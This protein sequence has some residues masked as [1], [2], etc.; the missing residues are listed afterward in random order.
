MYID[1]AP[2]QTL[3][4][5]RL[6]RHEFVQRLA[7]SISIAKNDNS[8]VIGLYGPWGSGKSSVLNLMK[9]KL[10]PRS[11]SQNDLQI[12]VLQFDPW[13]FNSANELIKSFFDLVQ[14]EIGDFVQD[15]DTKSQLN[16]LFSKYAEKLSY[17]KISFEPKISFL[18][19]LISF[20]AGIHRE[21]DSH[22]DIINLRYKIDELLKKN[23]IKVIVL[24]DNLDRLD[25]T[26]LMLML[27]LVK[28][29][30]DFPFFTYILAFDQ[31]QVLRVLDK[32]KD[33]DT[34]YLSK[35][36]QVD[37]NL[38]HIDQVSIDKYVGG[39][40]D[41]IEYSQEI[42][43]DED[44]SER[45]GHI[46]GN[47]IR[48]IL[49]KDFRTAKR[50]LN[51]VAFSMPLVK[52]EVNF[53]DF[54]A[55]E[56]IRVFFPN[57][58]QGLPNYKD[59]LTTFDTI[60]GDDWKMRKRVITFK[61]LLDWINDEIS[62]GR[63]GDLSASHIIDGI[64]NLLSQLFPNFGSFISNPNNPSHIVGLNYVN[65]NDRAQRIC[66]PSH[67][68]KYFKL[69]VQSSEIPTKLINEF[70][71]LLNSTN[72]KKF[73]EISSML[74][75]Y[76]DKS[77]YKSILQK[78]SLYSDSLTLE[79]KNIL[80][81]AILPITSILAWEEGLDWFTEARISYLLIFD[82]LLDKDD[83]NTLTDKLI[84]IVMSST[85][86][87]FAARVLSYSY[88]D[89]EYAKVPKGID[90]NVIKDVFRKRLYEEIVDQ[91]RNIF[92]LYPQSYNEILRV[93]RSTS[94]LDEE[95]NQNEYVYKT[96]DKNP[97]SIPKFLTQYVWKIAG[98]L[99]PANFEY[100][101]LVKYYQD[102]IL[103]NLLESHGINSSDGDLENFAVKEFIRIY[104]NKIS[105]IQDETDQ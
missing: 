88:P 79:G 68:D 91:D 53:A 95:Q 52:G 24:I 18:G 44:F 31:E 54:L 90:F 58:Y 83:T 89:Q 75:D 41:E 26:E 69:S 72:K 27:K 29:C 30:S 38:P 42:K 61:S 47:S 96:L 76:K 65:V 98:T 37:V 15:E 21:V 81:D 50:Y 48:G 103:Y 102:E 73:N 23:P 25:P 11:D 6:G 33:I 1:D 7:D 74:I 40:I 35:I 49:V 22:E 9:E 34:E 20:G 17:S 77:N 8:L 101:G 66:S 59:E 64:Q 84:Y 92:A 57:I 3:S 39:F 80:I 14:K 19:G 71:L 16:I 70:I 104:N 5:D 87:S 62:S 85:S 82:N 63:N 4:D 86:L 105:G 45:F 43:Y 60:P 32:S 99:R 100:S 93:W 10:K 78:I 12:L 13:F 51:A 97:E 2:I 67:F 36:I 56:C 28:L 55:L 46:Y 94:F